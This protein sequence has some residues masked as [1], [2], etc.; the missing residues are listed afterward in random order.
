MYGKS[1]R[2][3]LTLL[4][5]IAIHVIRKGCL[6]VYENGSWK[7]EIVMI[8][9]NALLYTRDGMFVFPVDFFLCTTS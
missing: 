7:K 8:I 4:H 1:M 5:V 6:L 9:F 3:V 2:S